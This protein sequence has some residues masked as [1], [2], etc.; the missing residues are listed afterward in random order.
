MSTKN[1]LRKELIKKRSLLPK[2]LK[3]A[4]DKEISERIINTEYFKNASQVLLF[5]ATGSE[6][7]TS[8]LR[9]SCIETGKKTYY[10]RCSDKNGAMRF[11]LVKS[12]S[13]LE[14]GMYN[15][16]EPK[17]GCPEYSE[18]TG[19]IAIVPALS[20]DMSFK[21]LGYGKGYY[22]R[23]LKDFHGVSICPCY[24]AMRTDMLPADEFD[25]SVDFV[26]AETGFYKKEG[27]L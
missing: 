18:L 8:L 14:C 16:R 15:I 20:A 1:E 19:D 6:F 26:A 22:D 2:Q 7:D 25:I 4:W 11:F 13:D 21:R 9:S 3:T 10:P 23:F 12:E 24:E 27:I 5:A 17:I